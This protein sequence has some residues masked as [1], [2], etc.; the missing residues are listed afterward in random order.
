MKPAK[1]TASPLF[2]SISVLLQSLV[3]NQASVCEFGLVQHRQVFF[4]VFFFFIFIII[5][6]PFLILTHWLLILP[7]DKVWSCCSSHTL[8]LCLFVEMLY[9]GIV[10]YTFYL[11][12]LFVFVFVCLFFVGMA[13]CSWLMRLSVLYSVPSLAFGGMKLYMVLFKPS[14]VSPTLCF[15]L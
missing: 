2:C 12:L 5:I 14:T 6:P 4:F 11:Y 3:L 9:F 13:F 15:L 7:N 8:P 10:L 1:I